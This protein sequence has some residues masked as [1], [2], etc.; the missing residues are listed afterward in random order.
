MS[1]LRALWHACAAHYF[2]VALEHLQADHP[3]LPYISIKYAMH[4]A[5]VEQFLAG[6]R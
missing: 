1:L 2:R 5:Q 3:D 6:G 4:R